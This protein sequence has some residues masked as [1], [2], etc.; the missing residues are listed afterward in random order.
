MFK[1]NQFILPHMGGSYKREGEKNLDF[2]MIMHIESRGRK[3]KAPAIGSFNFC[4]W[5]R[6]YF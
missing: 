1:I 2:A 5:G 3:I 6:A 4:V